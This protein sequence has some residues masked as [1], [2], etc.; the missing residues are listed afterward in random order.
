MPDRREGTLAVMETHPE[1]LHY[2]AQQSLVSAATVWVELPDGRPYARIHRDETAHGQP[3]WHWTG[4]GIGDFRIEAEAS[5]TSFLITEVTSAPFGR[6]RQRG[7]LLPRLAAFD[8]DGERFVVDVD[9][10]IT[11]A[12]SPRPTLGRIDLPAPWQARL[13]LAP[14][15]GQTLQTLQTLLVA[16]PLCHALQLLLLR[17]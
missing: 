10:R 2:R 17:I 7:F 16:A 4:G 5:A 13:E 14:S 6:I 9:G 12:G 1:H 8:A 3:R 11:T 15:S